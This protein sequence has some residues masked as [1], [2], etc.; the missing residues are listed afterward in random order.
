V[1]AVLAVVF[2]CGAALGSMF[3]SHY[4]HAKFAASARSLDM[5]QLRA[6]LALTPAQEKVVDKE[7]DEYAKYY[8]NIEE[9]REDVAELGKQRILDVL[10]PEQKKRFKEMFPQFPH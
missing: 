2:L 8:Q 3:T 9:E 10:N 5:Q 4:L 6:E 7:L 1:L